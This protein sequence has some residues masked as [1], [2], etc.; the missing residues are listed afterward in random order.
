MCATAGEPEVS[1]ALQAQLAA[2]EQQA[3]DKLL[4]QVR[5]S[6]AVTNTVASGSIRKA[7]LA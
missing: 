5:V 2:L 7:T 3:Q 1:P 6:L 4:E